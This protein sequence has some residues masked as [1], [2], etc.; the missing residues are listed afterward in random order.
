MVYAG[1]DTTKW[2]AMLGGMTR[3]LIPV[4]VEADNEAQAWSKRAFTIFDQPMELP[5]V[6]DVDGLKLLS[7]RLEADGQRVQIWPDRHK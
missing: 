7:V 6:E 4:W 3:F 1:D 5:E 2:A